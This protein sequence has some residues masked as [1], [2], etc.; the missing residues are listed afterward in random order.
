[1]A[2]ESHPNFIVTFNLRHFIPA[3]QFGIRT[4]APAE[5]LVI[6]ETEP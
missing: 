3:G 5:F 1:L 2:I 6:L 4:V